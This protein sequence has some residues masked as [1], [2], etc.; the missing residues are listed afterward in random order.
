MPDF[1]AACGRQAR[2]NDRYCRGCGDALVDDARDAGP[3]AEAESLVAR[4][5]LD[6]AIASIQRALG[7]REGAELHVGLA[8]LYLRRGGIAEAT[9]A[10][11]RAIALDPLCAVAHAYAGALLTRAGRIEEARAA[12][13]TAKALTPDDIV[14][15][16]KRAE[17]F[18][19]LGILDEAAV[20]LRH[21]LKNGGG[22]IETRNVAAK[23]LADVDRRLSRSVRR[24]PVALPTINPLR[25]VFGRGAPRPD[26]ATEAEV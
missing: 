9:R 23:L 10:L 4:G 19:A 26:V 15:S 20:E 25:R 14:V 2:I 18:V 21:G 7:V 8:T 11:D 12:L 6:D 22:A 1:C 24:T 5:R 3:V 17:F 13:D 16:L